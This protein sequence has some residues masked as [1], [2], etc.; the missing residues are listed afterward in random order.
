MH[1]PACGSSRV[2]RTE[3]LNAFDNAPTNSQPASWHLSPTQARAIPGPPNPL[4]WQASP[5]GIRKQGSTETPCVPHSFVG[6]AAAERGRGHGQR[7]AGEL[8]RAGTADGRRQAGLRGGPPPRSWRDPQVLPP[9][10]LAD[11]AVQSPPGHA[12]APLQGDSNPP[13][14]TTTASAEQ[15]SSVK[16]RSYLAVSW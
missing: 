6:R 14:G 2:D 4:G 15:G 1:N 11:L 7:R 9:T 12:H 10:V 5:E 13:A 3:K 16:W 8:H